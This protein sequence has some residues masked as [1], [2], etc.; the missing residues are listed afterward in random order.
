MFRNC[1]KLESSDVD[2]DGLWIPKNVNGANNWC[3]R[4]FAGDDTSFY[5]IG[6]DGTPAFETY[7]KIARD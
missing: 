4:M 7:V 1:P 6:G 5:P 2:A 3:D